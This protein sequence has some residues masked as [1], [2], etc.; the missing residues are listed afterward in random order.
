MTLSNTEQQQVDLTFKADEGR[1]PLPD[2]E[3]PAAAGGAETSSGNNTDT[4][5]VRVSDEK[6]KVLFSK[7]CRAGTSAS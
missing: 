5:F 3:G 2:G 4:A 6:I 1:R 7:A